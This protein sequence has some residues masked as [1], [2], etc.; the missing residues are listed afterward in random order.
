[1]IFDRRRPGG[2]GRRHFRPGI[3][4]TPI[5]TADEVVELD[6]DALV[7]LAHGT[8]MSA[9]EAEAWTAHLWD[10]EVTPLFP[11]LNRPAPPFDAAN[12]PL[13]INNPLGR[14]TTSGIL[15][16]ALEKLGYIRGKVSEGGS[17]YDFT[18]DFRKASVVVS[19]NVEGIFV[20]GG[21]D[22]EAELISLS[23][24]RVEGNDVIDRRTD[25]PLAS[26]RH[27]ALRRGFC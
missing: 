25:L 12:P 20:R 16:S 7:R 27:Y 5:D 4:R 8:R 19:V 24:V 18:K 15:S 26:R 22:G 11:Q 2:A 23:F 14:T 1:M 17:I 13:A 9:A 21:F 10:Y 6:K 3:D